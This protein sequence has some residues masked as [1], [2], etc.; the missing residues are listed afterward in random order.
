MLSERNQIQDCMLHYSIYVVFS[1]RCGRR[2]TI[3]GQ[4]GEF[5]EAME[6]FCILTYVKIHRTLHKKM[7]IFCMFNFLY[8]NLNFF[9]FK[10]P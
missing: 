8:V 1:C 4:H 6:L 10:Y 9:N 5:G 7:S 3:K 2:V